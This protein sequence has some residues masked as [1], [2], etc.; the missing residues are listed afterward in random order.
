MMKNRRLFILIMIVILIASMAYSVTESVKPVEATG[1]H[2]E[3]L[4]DFN[5]KNIE[6]A[7]FTMG[8]PFVGIELK[9][10]KGY[11]IVNPGYDEFE[12]EL[13]L[14]GI[15]IKVASG[16]LA[17]TLSSMFMSMLYIGLI[18]ALVLILSKQLNFGKKSE[19]RIVKSDDCIKFDDIAGMTETKAEIRFAV[20]SLKMVD[21]LNELGGRPVKGLML[22]GPPGT[23]KTMLAKAIAGEAGVPFI[24]ASGSDFVE[25]FVGVGASRIRNLW[26]FAQD[27]SPCVLFIDEID[28]VGGKRISGGFGG[29]SE[30]NN[31]LNA[32]LQL[33]DGIVG[34]S[35]VLVVGA[36]NRLDDL[37]PALV[38]PGRFD[39]VLYIGAPNSKED[40]DAILLLHLRN[41]KVG[42][43]FNFNQ[44]S[45]HLIGLTGAQIEQVTNEAVL[46]SLV[47]GKDGVIDNESIDKSSM[48]L[49]AGGVAIKRH[50]DRDLKIAAVHEAGHAIISLVRGIEVSKISVV[51]YSSGV[52][53]VTVNDI[54]TD[55]K[56]KT[57]KNLMYDIDVLLGGLVA[58][59]VIFGEHSN[60]CS[61]DLE[62]ATKI[63]F[64]MIDNY[65]MWEG[66][67]ARSI[68][69][70]M[71][72]SIDTTIYDAIDDLLKDRKKEVVSIL[73]EKHSYIEKLADLIIENETVV[74][75][76]LK[77]VEEL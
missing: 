8:S 38:R 20:D 67:G 4:K 7:T 18:L 76:T 1:T 68:V 19:S 47:D 22:Q 46:T 26:K 33:M 69:S 31:T 50:S 52:G 9:E 27:N 15:E 61:N 71:T 56:F 28:A 54:N 24:S 57:R 66:L 59:D 39:K 17:E 70:K 77:M 10:G 42:E 32:L 72:S 74:E 30:Q 48:K 64:T 62:V 3:F 51:P 60:G 5:S 73:T 2:A 53:G 36:T 23:G 37:D 43:N 29:Q 12:H 49:L 6:T 44:A 63:A 21:K 40:R 14:A 16:K 45:R 13:L 34:N 11:T 58:E 75:P 41:K 65:G 35:G 25:M 55:E